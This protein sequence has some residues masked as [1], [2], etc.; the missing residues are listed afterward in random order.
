[1]IIIIEMNAIEKDFNQGFGNCI[2]MSREP[3]NIENRIMDSIRDH[4]FMELPEAIKVTPVD[5][6]HDKLT[7]GLKE[8]KAEG[9]LSWRKSTVGAHYVLNGLKIENINSVG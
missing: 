1:M 6:L 2:F 4:Q 8:G 9:V 3:K 5:E 7:L